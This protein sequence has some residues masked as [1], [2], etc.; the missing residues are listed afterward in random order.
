MKKVLIPLL[1]VMSFCFLAAVESDPSAVVG[2]VKYDMTAGNNLV[3]LPMEQGF[4]LASDVG[5]YAG[6]NIVQKWNPA[7]E[8]WDPV[9]SELMPGWWDNDFAV[10][11]GD[12]LL[13]GVASAGALYSVGGLPTPATYS[14]VAGANAIMIPLNRSD[15]TM[16]SDAGTEIGANVVQAW[17]SVSDSW[18]PVISELMP[19]WW[20]NDFSISI[21]KPLLVGVGAASTWPAPPAPAPT[22]KLMMSGSK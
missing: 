3:A 18:D 21:G 19:G 20:D 16:A 14:L 8:S 7:S 1:L 11:V 10:G 15:L 13:I 6:A 17:D 4:T 12:I 2:Y 9:I 22:R 5:T